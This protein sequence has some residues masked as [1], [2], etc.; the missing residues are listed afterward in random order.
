[1]VL[2]I[3]KLSKSWDILPRSLDQSD[4]FIIWQ[5]FE[6]PISIPEYYVL[7]PLK[8]RSHYSLFV[9]TSSSKSRSSQVQHNSHPIFRIIGQYHEGLQGDHVRR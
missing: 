1:M 3:C 8:I 2:Y 6:L 4:Q 9:R 5:L 7:T